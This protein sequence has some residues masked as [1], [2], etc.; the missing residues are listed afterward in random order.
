MLLAPELRGVGLGSY[1]LDTA[2]EF[3]KGHGYTTVFLWTV[4]IL[5]AAVHLYQSAGF[6]LKEQK[7]HRIWGA[8]L[9]EQR[10]ELQL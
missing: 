4:C 9:T 3:C 8:E 10:Y 6:K 5:A 2:L 7:T 1:L